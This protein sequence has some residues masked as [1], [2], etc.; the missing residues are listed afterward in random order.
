MRLAFALA[1]LNLLLFTDV[2]T[3]KE[4]NISHQWPGETDARDRAARIFAQTV[5]SRIPE[6]TFRIYPQLSFKIKAEE[7]FD[8]LR[9]G[10]LDMTVY[11]VRYAVTK[12]PEFS[13]A[14]LPG[15]Y[16]SLAIVHGLKNSK[17]LEYLQGLADENGVHIVAWWWAPGG[18]ATRNREIAGPDTI[19]G[20]KLRG[21]ERLFDTMLKKAGAMPVEMSSNDIYEAMRSGRVD[22]AATSYETFVS[23]KIFEHARYFTAGSPGLWMTLDALM[24]SKSDWD[25]LSDDERDA[26]EAAAEA[27]EDY[28]MGTQ[29]EAEKNFIDVFTKAGAKYRRFTWD[30]YLAWLHL[31]Q[32]TAWAE[33]L[34]ISP[35]AETM[36]LDTLQTILSNREDASDR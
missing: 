29:R 19:K 36:L 23:T 9:S 15:L 24:I 5:T 21:G 33:Y 2:A 22:G 28:F 20:L 26:F 12:I 16:P 6:T 4:F 7:Q 31:A 8:A 1:A 34:S 32:A 25:S 18:F 17:L 13:L 11:P 35:A 30:D 27:S 3:T 10:R 14:V